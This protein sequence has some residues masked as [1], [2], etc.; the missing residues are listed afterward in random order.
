MEHVN[1]CK[2]FMFY[3]FSTKALKQSL[4]LSVLSRLWGT[5]LSDVVSDS[6]VQT[7]AARTLKTHWLSR[8]TRGVVEG[9]VTGNQQRGVH[10]IQ[11]CW[12]SRH[13]GNRRVSSGFKTNIQNLLFILVWKNKIWQMTLFHINKKSKCT[14]FRSLVFWRLHIEC[15]CLDFIFYFFKS[16]PIL[17][18]W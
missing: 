12:P 7:K 8:Q 4:Q 13:H 5:S 15:F 14:N 16:T 18:L 11:L 10:S 2:V 17:N 6:H 1:K 3:F 9:K